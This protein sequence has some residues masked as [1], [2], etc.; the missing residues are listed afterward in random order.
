[1]METKFYGK[2]FFYVQIIWTFQKHFIY[3]KKKINK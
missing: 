2:S 1:M 3:I